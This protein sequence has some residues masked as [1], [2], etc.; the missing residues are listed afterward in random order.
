MM[1]VLQT[2][3]LTIHGLKTANNESKV[4]FLVN[5]RHRAAVLIFAVD[6]FWN[7]TPENSEGD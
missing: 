4:L 7:V 6:N 3:V 5:F 2:A 1:V